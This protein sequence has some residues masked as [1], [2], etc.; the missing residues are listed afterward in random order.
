MVSVNSLSPFVVIPRATSPLVGGQQSSNSQSNANASSAP[1]VAKTGDGTL[2]ASAQGKIDQLKAI[3]RKVKA[4]EQAHVAAGGELI[5][6]G[7]NF[8]YQ[9]GPDGKLYA[10]GG[11]VSIDTSPGRTPEDTVV[12]AQ[13][14][15]AAALAPADPSA[16]DR[17]VAADASAMELSAR[18]DV[19]ASKKSG[20]ASGES[21]ENDRKGAETS[22]P[23]SATVADQMVALYTAVSRSGDRT[24]T[25]SDAV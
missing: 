24:S 13:R 22:S 10:I 4:H 20:K 17:R 15:R 14:I 1:S 21:G 3:D 7:V 2:S 18:N 9:K 5:R 19:D 23:V 8:S 12:R 6:G 11:D 16:Q 25:F